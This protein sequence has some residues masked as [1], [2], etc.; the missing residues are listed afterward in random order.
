MEA[1]MSKPAIN[2]FC[3][4]IVLVI[5][6]LIG[7]AGGN[8]GILKRVQKPTENGLHQDWKEYT[9]YYRRNLAFVYKIK[10]DRKII[11]DNSWVKVSSEDM[12]TKSKILDPTWVKEIIGNND[13]MFG[14]LVHR[15]QDMAN[16]TIID[17]NT[18]QLYYTYVRT[19]GR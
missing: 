6:S 7:C 18:V 12:M 2:L 19:S 4:F 1:T 8:R 17:E 5:F 10:N 15:Y 16:V 11:L 9:V 13:E 3:L 14:Y